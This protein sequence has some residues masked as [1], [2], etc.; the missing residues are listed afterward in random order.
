MTPTEVAILKT[1]LYADVFSFPLTLD[2]LHRYLIHDT[3]LKKSTIDTALKKSTLLKQYLCMQ[4]DYICLKTRQS[5][6][7][8]RREREKVSLDLWASANKYGVWLSHIPF[9][10]MVAL[11][12]ALAVR[13]PAGIDD[14][15]DYL[16]VTTRGRVWLARAFAVLLVKIVQLFGRELCPNYVLADNQLVQS[17]QDL[18]TA[19]EVAQMIPIYGQNTYHAIIEQNPWVQEHL[20]NVVSYNI[21][22]N[23][24]YH[25]RKIAEWMLGGWLGDKIEAWEYQL[26]RCR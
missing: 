24:T 21:Q 8:I 5:I 16:L 20:P 12:G 14:D 2:D 9:V 6:I 7:D 19:H 17:R 3:A 10:R 4:D 1:I 26:T 22:E 11:T 15:F 18:Y 23:Q 25:L 13:N